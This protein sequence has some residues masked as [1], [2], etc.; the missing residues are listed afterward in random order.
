LQIKQ[1]NK[2]EDLGNRSTVSLLIFP[3]GKLN[4]TYGCLI[5]IIVLYS[6]HLLVKGVYAI[7]SVTL[8][9]CMYVFPIYC[10]F[11]QSAR[12]KEREIFCDTDEHFS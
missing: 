1:H 4:G 8:C 3:D 12:R 9:A 10:A 11:Y 7:L 5:V 2:D 6:A